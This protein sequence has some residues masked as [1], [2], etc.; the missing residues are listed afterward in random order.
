MNK[1]LLVLLFL[2]IGFSAYLGGR[3]VFLTDNFYVET[4]HKG[5]I[6]CF[7]FVCLNGSC[8]F[9]S[10]SRGGSGLVYVEESLKWEGQDSA[11]IKIDTP[12][13]GSSPTSSN[14]YHK[15]IK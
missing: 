1:L 11:L 10:N 5:F 15:V 12:N 8:L 13:V 7:E 14:Y 2:S 9:C 3:Q 4:E 6:D